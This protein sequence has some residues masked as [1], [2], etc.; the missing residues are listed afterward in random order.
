MSYLHA[1][2]L[3][4]D[5]VRFKEGELRLEVEAVYDS[6]EQRG[7]CLPCFVFVVVYFF[8]IRYSCRSWQKVHEVI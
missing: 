8:D 2:F 1:L 5:A 4:I 7:N 3:F 6:K